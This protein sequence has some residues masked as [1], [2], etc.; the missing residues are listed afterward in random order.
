MIELINIFEHMSFEIYNHMTTQIDVVDIS[1]NT[2]DNAIQP[3][4]VSTEEVQQEEVTHEE[5]KQDEV[6]TKK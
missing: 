2:N 5:V 1:D 4:V 6:H 3:P